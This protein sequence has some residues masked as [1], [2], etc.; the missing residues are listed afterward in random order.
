MA[1][2]SKI[3]GVTIEL[4]ADASGVQKGLESV[5]KSISVTQRSLRDVEKLLKLDPGNAELLAQKQQYLGEMVEETAKKLEAERQMLADLDAQGAGGADVVAQQQALQREIIATTK[6]LEK[7]QQ[8]SAEAHSVMAESLKTAGK[9]L[10]DTGSK[11][12]QAGQSI[13]SVGTGMTKAVTGPIVAAGAA[14]GAAWKEVDAG[15]DTVTQKTGA[16]GEALES[17]QNSAKNLAR[18]IPT[19]FATAGEAIGEV[20]TRFGLMGESLETLSGSFVKFASLNGQDVTSAVTGVA[21][22]VHSFGLT[23]ADAAGILDTLTAVSQKTGVSA[24]TLSSLLSA[25][26]A[27]FKEMGLSVDQAATFLGQAEASG[28][29]VSTVMTGLSKALKNATKDGIP[30]SQALQTMQH[31]LLDT[32]T[33][34]QAAY[35]LFG[36]SGAGIATA[37]QNGAL[38]F[39]AMKSAVLDYGGT[40]ETTFEQMQDAPDE[41]QM[42]LNDLK[43]TGAELADSFMADMLPVLKD[44]LGTL[45]DLCEWF[46][47]LDEGTQSNIVKFALLAA[48]LGPV[49]TGIGGVVSTIGGLISIVGTIISGIG[50]FIGVLTGGAGLAGAAGAAGGGI[51][52]LLAAAAPFLPWIAA[53]VAAITGIIAVIKNWDSITQFFGETW[54]KVTSGAKEA[55][56]GFVGTVTGLGGKISDFFSGLTSKALTW[57]KD[58]IDNLVSGITGKWDEVAESA[59]GIASKIADFIGFSLP[60][61]GPLSKTDTFMPDMIDVLAKGITS[62]TSKLQKPVT[63]LADTLAVQPQSEAAAATLATGSTQSAGLAG[64]LELLGQYLPEIA[65][66]KQV[67]MDSGALVGQLA[68]GMD[69][70]LGIRQRRRGRQ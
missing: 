67:V 28:T 21:D 70:A 22:V 4:T 48:A 12:Q 64:L 50:G 32:E 11:I 53:A 27:E 51:A 34:L 19:D 46:T 39:T 38:D 60:K 68:P 35:D 15:L 56:S 69:T 7:L 23:S 58:L 45:R 37:V 57:G 65:A 18:N 59:G 16:T 44:L 61:E 52:G 62:S 40:V 31:D 6:E 42:A 66:Q 20:N 5:N 24:S 36:K 14:A 3:R 43:I 2:K 8:K 63:A 49:I 17:M 47:G 25:N 13:T 29:D 9:A 30:L 33:G 41:A 10:Q 26:A 55:W 54:E 1:K